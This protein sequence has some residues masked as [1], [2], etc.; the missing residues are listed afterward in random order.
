[1]GDLEL[2]GYHRIITSSETRERLQ[3]PAGLSQL[4]QRPVGLHCPAVA[5]SQQQANGGVL[6]AAVCLRAGSGSNLLSSSII[7]SPVAMN[8]PP[9]QA[10]WDLL[11]MPQGGELES[12][13]EAVDVLGEEPYLCHGAF[14]RCHL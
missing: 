9:H 4:C 6:W 14:R 11:A 3:H 13:R 10:H 5:P 2:L 7:S 1:M 8:T 12:Y